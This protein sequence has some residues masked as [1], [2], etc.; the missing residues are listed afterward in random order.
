MEIVGD[1]GCN[2]QQRWAGYEH[3]SGNHDNHSYFGSDQRYGD[4]DG[5]GGR[6]DFNLRESQHRVGGGGL[7]SAIY[8]DRDLQQR[9][10]PEPDHDGELEV[11]SDFGSDD[12]PAHRIGRERGGGNN[13]HY[14]H[15]GED[16]RLGYVDGDTGNT[17]F[18]FDRGYSGHGVGGGWL[19]AAVHGDGD[20]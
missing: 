19:H 13:V 12:E 20:L 16:Q 18:G 1:L 3:C 7:D 6:P 10:N 14:S 4:A 11:I 5:D 9:L 8:R 2:D 15:L 17:G